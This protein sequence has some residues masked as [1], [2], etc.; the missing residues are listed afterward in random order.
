MDN[1]IVQHCSGFSIPP[2]FFRISKL[3]RQ[4]TGPSCVLGG[5]SERSEEFLGAFR[6]YLLFRVSPG[7][8]GRLPCDQTKI[9][10]HRRP[11]CLL[12][13]QRRKQWCFSSKPRT[14]DDVTPLQK[15]S[16]TIYVGHQP[17]IV[18]AFIEKLFALTQPA[19]SAERRRNR[20]GERR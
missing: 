11:D 20:D 6:Q 9:R 3:Q 19:N 18:T 12:W 10:R 4:A 16:R 14:D 7:T 2:Q 8:D 13:E 1:W 17:W 15:R 5:V